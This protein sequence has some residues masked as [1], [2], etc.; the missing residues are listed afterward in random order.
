MK[1]KYRPSGKFTFYS[2]SPNRKNKVGGVKA[3]EELQFKNGI[4][5]KMLRF[6]CQ[7]YLTNVTGGNFF[8]SVGRQNILQLILFFKSVQQ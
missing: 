2:N 3:A 1:N 8:T 5:T 6:L 4:P 7:V